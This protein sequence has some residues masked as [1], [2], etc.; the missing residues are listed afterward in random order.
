MKISKNATNLSDVI[1]KNF[2]Q[3]NM[4]WIPEY[5]IALVNHEACGVFDNIRIESMV[6]YFILILS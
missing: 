5:L 1:S 6:I 3:E 2:F 4:S